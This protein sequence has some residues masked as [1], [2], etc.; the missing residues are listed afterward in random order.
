MSVG[1]RITLNLVRRRSPW[2]PAG[3][4]ALCVACVPEQRFATLGDFTL[5]NGEIIRG[6][7]IGYRTLGELDAARSNAVL[8][9]P[10]AM[11]T[12]REL[13]R[14]IVS[15]GLLDHSGIYAIAVDTFGNGVS[16]SPSNGAGQRGSAFPRISMRDIVEGQYQLLTRVLGV[17]HLKA[18]IGTSAG[19]MQAF[20]WATSHPEFLDSAIAIAGSPRSSPAD[21][22]RWF[23][24]TDELRRDPA[25]K[26]VARWLQRG[27]PQE[28]FRQLVIDPDDFDRQAEAIAAFDVSAA[29]GG[30]MQRAAAAVRARLLVVV[31]DRDDVVDPAPALEFAR[32]ARAEVV[33]LDGRCGHRAPACESGAVQGAIARFLRN[34]YRDARK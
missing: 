34:E 26:R 13:L 15:G 11:G 25:W 23:A 32:L 22:Q 16:S 5:E 33:V 28:A 17:S 24:W 12:S 30:S 18:V 27:A 6:C 7:R 19:G 20:Q 10:W 14:Q 21:R 1:S 2:W 31:P 8:L 4:L 9:T 29:F 3:L